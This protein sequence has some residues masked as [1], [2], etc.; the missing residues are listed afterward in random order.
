M[1]KKGISPLIAAVMLIAFTMAVGSIFAQW[2][3]QLIQN[4]Q[5]GVTEDTKSITSAARSNIE[6]VETSYSSDSNKV[7][8]TVQNDGQ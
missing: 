4:A 6:I 2:T 7:I 8:V 1:N 5:Q 3:P